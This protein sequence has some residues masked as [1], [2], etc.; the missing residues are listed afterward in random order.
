MTHRILFTALFDDMAQ[1]HLNYYCAKDIG[2]KALY[3]DAVTPAEAGCKYILSAYP[4][5][6]IV[7]LGM[8]G[9]SQGGDEEPV[10]LRKA[11]TKSFSEPGK[12]SEFSVLQYRL[13]QF[14]DDIN[15]EGADLNDQLSKEEQEQTAAFLRDFFRRKIDPEG[16]KQYSRYFHYLVQEPS[17][18]TEL[19]SALRARLSNAENDLQRY[20]SWICFYLYRNLKA[21]NKLEPLESNSSV[22]IRY[23]PAEGSS[24]LAS[25]N[26]MMALLRSMEA[27]DGVPDDTELYLC[28]QGEHLSTMFSLMNTMNLT[29]IM[30]NA[31]I[32]IARVIAERHLH[33]PFY[34]MQDK[35]EDFN[36]SEL[37]SAT[38][39]FLQ[40]GKTDLLVDYWERANLQNKKI[41]RI[42]Y[43]IRNIDSG[44]SLC[45]ISDIER[46]IQSLRSVIRNDLPIG[47]KTVIEQYFEVVVD[48]IRRD[49]GSLLEAD[50]LSFID[51]VKWAYRKGFWQQTLTLVES[52]APQDFVEKGIF[53]YSDGERS[54]KRAIEVLGQTYYDLKPFEKYKLDDVPHYYVKYYNRHRV[55]SSGDG[56]TYQMNYAQYR[57]RELDTR[58]ENEIRA[59]TVCPDRSAL[60]DLLFSY[61]HLS[62]V[63]NSTNHAAEE[64]GGFYTVKADDDPSERM[65]TITQAVDYFLSS[66]DKVIRLINGKTANVVTVKTIE[67]IEYSKK[68]REQYR[69]DTRNTSEKSSTQNNTAT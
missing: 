12:Y 21:T 30:P 10:V 11:N 29:K 44:I 20:L 28:L 6:E 62:D 43:A 56:D 66:Y 58:D 52:R 68:L 46:G 47:G 14:F 25:L 17:V 38:G 51:L 40:Y 26:Q 61:Y 64:F 41:E 45:D 57:V 55:S 59:L 48:S 54:R 33:Q 39:A 65:K 34:E 37:L 16:E 50:Q 4:I 42:I 69:R 35:T 49:Y 2:T 32:R 67:L 3:C 5:D 60:Q 1:P 18:L 13:A 63:R 27:D 36:I 31:Q 19:E 53:F 7:V 15:A 23:L 9:A 24:V 8:G 22:R